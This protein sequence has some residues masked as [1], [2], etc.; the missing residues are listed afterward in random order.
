MFKEKANT[1]IY[2]WL[3]KENKTSSM[4]LYITGPCP[5]TS[6]Q[7]P[8]YISKLYNFCCL[9]EN[10]FQVSRTTPDISLLCRNIYIGFPHDSLQTRNWLV[11]YCVCAKH[12]YGDRRNCLANV[13]LTQTKST[14]KHYVQ[15]Y[16]TNA[17]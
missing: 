4:F 12:S 1:D 11:R 17:G 10:S 8:F 6:S 5:L 3:S 9:I 13:E 15:L 14:L 2:I 16:F 7:S